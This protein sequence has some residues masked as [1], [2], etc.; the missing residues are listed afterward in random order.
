MS[1]EYTAVNIK[2]VPRIYEINTRIQNGDIQTL[3]FSANWTVDIVN[4]QGEV[5][6]NR[7]GGLT[8]I[9]ITP[10]RLEAVQPVLDDLHYQM[11]L[12]FLSL[13]S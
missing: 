3:Q 2:Y 4:D 6:G 12:D 7:G 11:E 8:T 10:E 1:N 9:P 13:S 5:I